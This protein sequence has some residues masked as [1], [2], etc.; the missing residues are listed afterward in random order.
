MVK[1]SA[2]P[3]AAWMELAL[4]LGSS[5][6]DAR[7]VYWQILA[8]RYGEPHRGYHTVAHVASCL[9]VLDETV[10][11]S[12]DW[13]PGARL[14]L[15]FHDVIY[16]PLRKDNEE[17]SADVL[18]GACGLMG[19]PRSAS[20]AS[21]DAVLATKHVGEDPVLEL[22]RRVLDADLASLGFAWDEF[23][24]NSAGI[25]KE[26][27]FVPE[28]AYRSGRTKILQGFLD[29]PVLYFTE[30]CRSL[31]DARARENLRRAVSELG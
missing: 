23:V 15:W 18:I 26:Y 30:E 29:R 17:R 9:G 5:E 4:S 25:R 13:L 3:D 6:Q 1:A 22:N 20:F 21:A 16:D 31:Y 2:T 7:T 8:P 27:S 12:P 10:A 14:A 19:V 24:A 28:D 11:G